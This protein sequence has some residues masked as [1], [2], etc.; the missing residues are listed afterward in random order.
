LIA[1]LVLCACQTPCTS[2]PTLNERMV[3]SCRDGT[4][5]NTVFRADE[6]SV[7][8]TGHA[9]LVLPSR[10]AGSGYRYARGGV[11]LRGRGGQA[12]WS[13]PGDGELLCT[14][15]LRRV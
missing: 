5:L 14:A 15:P 13:R 4:R 6:V 3:F 11:E 9:P 2:S 12:I 8:Q 1:A 10:Y 7:D